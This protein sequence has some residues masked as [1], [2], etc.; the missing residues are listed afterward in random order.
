MLWVAVLLLPL[1]SVLLVVMDRVEERLLA[2]R[3]D[4]RRHAATGRHLRLVRHT[5][6]APVADEAARPARPRAA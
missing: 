4:K 2:P 6:P 1:L 5:G 3:S